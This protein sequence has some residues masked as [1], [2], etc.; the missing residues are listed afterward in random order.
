MRRFAIAF[1][2]AQLDP[3][4]DN[5]ENGDDRDP[6][7]LFRLGLQRGIHRSAHRPLTKG[8]TS[9]VGGDRGG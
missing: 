5:K 6:A 4:K 2:P 7:A 9:D 3:S 8:P 1:E